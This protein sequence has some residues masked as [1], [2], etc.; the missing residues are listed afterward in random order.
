MGSSC[1]APQ[2]SFEIKS[3][4][5]SRL[6][7]TDGGPGE[8]RPRVASFADGSHSTLARVGIQACRSEMCPRKGIE[9]NI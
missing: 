9:C 3:K 7:A 8:R 1:K 5:A 2:Y 4:W 6:L